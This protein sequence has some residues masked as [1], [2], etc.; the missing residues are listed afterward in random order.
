MNTEKETKAYDKEVE[1]YL[2]EG[3]NYHANT[4]KKA[5]QDDLEQLAADSFHEGWY[6]A[7]EYFNSVK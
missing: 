2:K 6:K 5:D 4:I 3:I 1:K 7:L